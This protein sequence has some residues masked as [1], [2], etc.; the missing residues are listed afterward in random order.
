MEV[1]I[2]SIGPEIPLEN[3]AVEEGTHTISDCLHG[4]FGEEVLV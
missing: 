3:G 4:A 2:E 1:V